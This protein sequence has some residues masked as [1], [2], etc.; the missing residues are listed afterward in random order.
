MNLVG[1]Q[2]FSRKGMQ[3]QDGVLFFPDDPAML[4][5]SFN[6]KRLVPA[7]RYS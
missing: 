7:R 2:N 3:K 5:S 6:K 4:A 1:S